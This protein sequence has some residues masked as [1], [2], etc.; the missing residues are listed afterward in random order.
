MRITMNTTMA[1][2]MLDHPLVTGVVY[3]IPDKLGRAFIEKKWALEYPGPKE[4]GK[5]TG[6]EITNS[7]ALYDL[8][9]SMETAK[10]GRP[11]KEVET[12]TAEAPENEM[13]EKP[14]RRVVK[15]NA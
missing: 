1:G 8:L 11:K 2:P 12:A 13:Q 10:R 9:G 6:V 4:K 5:K 15:T 7:N 14:K 3:R